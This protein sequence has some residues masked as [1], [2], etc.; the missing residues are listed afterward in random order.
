MKLIL[1]SLNEASTKPLANENAVN[2]KQLLVA[3]PAVLFILGSGVANAGEPVKDTGAM[4]CVNDKWDVKEPEKGHK[5][6]D[7]AMRCVLIP[8]DPAEPTI[9]QDCLGN[10]EYMPDASWKGTGTCTDN[11]PGGKISLTWAEGSQLKEYTY[12]KTGGTGKYQGVKG[13]G[14]YMYENLTDTLSGGRYKGTIQLP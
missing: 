14:T 11:Y 2:L 3:V 4:A 7:A 12:T 13:G 10:Y 5:L 1:P 6:V 9:N 8:D